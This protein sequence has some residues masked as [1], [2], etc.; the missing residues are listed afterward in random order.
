MPKHRKTVT[1]NIYDHPAYYD[2]IFGAEWAKERNFLVAACDTYAHC[3]VRRLFEPA[4]GT[5]RLLFRLAKLGYGVTGLDLNPHAVAYCNAR[6]ERHA[7][8]GRAVVGDM[9]DFHLRQKADAAFNLINSFRHLP[10]EK[11]AAA[12]LRCIRDA[13]TP[14]GIY[15]LGLHLTPKGESDCEA[16][17]WQAKRG[18]VTVRSHLWT[19]RLDRRKREETVGIE[20]D[21]T[22]PRQAL[23]LV[24]EFVFRTYSAKQMANLIHKVEGLE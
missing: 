6:M 21:V 2:I 24:D 18:P 15:L 7:L 1:G 4:C 13:L 14:G 8:D 17:S 3:K 5:G 12:H 16:E 22:S 19:K 10:D 11:S 9:S 23:T 20:F